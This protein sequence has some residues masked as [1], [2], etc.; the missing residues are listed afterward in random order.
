MNH[1]GEGKSI[2]RKQQRT[3]WAACGP[4]A[5]AVTERADSPISVEGHNCEDNLP[6]LN[7]EELTVCYHQVSIPRVELII[8]AHTVTF[9]AL[10]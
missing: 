2:W 10:S 6:V 5:V 7:L 4:V 8:T 9:E 1:Y 3:P